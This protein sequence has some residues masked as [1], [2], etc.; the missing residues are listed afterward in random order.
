MVDR[1][2]M[3]KSCSKYSE[4]FCK[5]YMGF[6]SPGGTNTFVPGMQQKKKFSDDD[7]VT[8]ANVPV[9]DEHN[10]K[11]E[12]LDINFDEAMLK[13]IIDR[14]NKRIQDTN[15]Y[16]VVTAGHTEEDGPE[17]E[18]LGFATNFKMGEFGK[19]KRKCIYCDL[20]I[21]KEKYERAKGLPRRSIELWHKDLTANSINLSKARNRSPIDTIS[22]L[23]ATRPARDLGV[24]HFS[25]EKIT[26]QMPVRLSQN[27]INDIV[28][29]FA[30]QRV[31]SD[32]ATKFAH[33]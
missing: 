1:Y 21:R 5:S 31:I 4:V 22:L 6:S 15:D 14:C 11:E 16:P 32:I 8:M 28:K 9:F 2:I 19:D 13:K 3:P 25:K 26:Y 30:M 7:F 12:D 23:G 24:M 17:P 33:Q 10:G 29:N 27:E 18:T 20:M